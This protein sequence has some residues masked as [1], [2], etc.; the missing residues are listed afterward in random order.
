MADLVR[1]A[2]YPF[3][4]GVR[5]TVRELGP[6]VADLLGGRLHAH[7]RERALARVQAVLERDGRLVVSPRD[8]RGA[9]EELLAYAVAKMLLV[10]LGDRILAQRYAEAEARRAAAALAKDEGPALLEVAAHLRVPVDTGTVPWRIHFADY[11]QVA[12]VRDPAWKLLHRPVA[13]GYVPLDRKDLLRLCQEALSERLADEILDEMSRPVPQ[14]LR[15]AL[16]PYV[17]RV[18]PQLEEAQKNWNTGDFGPVRRELFPPCITE[19]FGQMKRGEMIPHHARFAFASF[20]GTIGM[21]SEQAIDFFREVPNFDPEKSRYQIEHITGE[22]GVE[23]YTPPGCQ[24]MQTNGCCPLAKRDNL[25]AKIKHPLSYYRARIR[26]AA[27]DEQKA[28]E[29]AQAIARKKGKA[30]APADDDGIPAVATA[31]RSVD[32]NRGKRGASP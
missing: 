7:T 6:D 23:K 29:L 26:F 10:V 19:I 25:C 18:K 20:L 2:Y 32:R 15:D 11:L 5:E 24:W 12:P 14:D 22:R 31:A 3:L 1:L 8:E 21:D 28:D 27:E 30:P 13:A 9:L 4:P 16:A 17:E